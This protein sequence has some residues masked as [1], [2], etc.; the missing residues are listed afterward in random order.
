MKKIKILIFLIVILL[1]C[2]LFF[3]TKYY[4]SNQ[5]KTV[6]VIKE[7]P[8]EKIVEKEVQISG[9]TI[10]SSMS[11]IG[12]LCTAE[13]SYTHVEHVNSSKEIKDFKIPFTKTSFIY[14]YD[15]MIMAGLDFTKIQIDKDDT[16][17]IITVTLPNVEIISS[18]VDQDSFQLYDEKNNIFN[19]I[20]VTDVAN[21]FTNLKNSE[22]E[23]AIEKGLFD[24]AKT[25]AILLVE[26]F[27]HGSFDIE[28]YEIKVLFQD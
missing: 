25:N 9:E 19:P 12:K 26:N 20:S 28:D 22:E 27:M 3:G 1:F 15:G 18:E 21:S 23:K 11:N 7:V 4:Y 10:R 24:R 5:I 2:L 13:Y 6:E 17:K 8:V 16:E 14:S